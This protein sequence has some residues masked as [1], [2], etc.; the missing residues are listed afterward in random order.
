[1]DRPARPG[2]LATFKG[3]YTQMGST[4]RIR[5]F[6]L[7]L[8]MYLGGY[9]SQDI[10]NATF[11]Y[12]IVFALGAS[13]VTASNVLGAMAVVQLLS[14]AL[15][16]QL[17]LKLPPA[18]SYR[19]AVSLFIA[20]VIG[21]LLLYALSP[22]QLQWWLLVP[23]TAA[24]LGRGGLNYIPWSLYNYMADVDEIVTGKRRE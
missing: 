12:F 6:R 18:P 14:V 17:C 24:G 20:G 11:T 22:Q 15:F 4:L 9:I 13:V 10:F 19:I 5:A 1:A 8:G 3:L 23:V 16:I 21:F 2:L 7:H